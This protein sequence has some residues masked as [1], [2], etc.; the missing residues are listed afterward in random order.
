MDEYDEQRVNGIA[1]GFVVREHAIM[2][3]AFRELLN[4]NSERYCKKYNLQ[5]DDVYK[6]SVEAVYEHIADVCW[7]YIKDCDPSAPEP[8][9]SE[10]E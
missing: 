1:V 7:V 3:E 4:G 5:Y 9:D 10:G 8:G 6:T 2:R